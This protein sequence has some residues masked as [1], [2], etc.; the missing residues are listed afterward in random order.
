MI[1]NGTAV[2]SFVS[3]QRNSLIIIRFLSSCQNEIQNP[4]DSQTHNK[5]RELLLKFHRFD[6]LTH[7]FFSFFA[8]AAIK[9]LGLIC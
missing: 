5:P 8:L 3:Y 4:K 1:N 7:I 2:I 9:S 6:K